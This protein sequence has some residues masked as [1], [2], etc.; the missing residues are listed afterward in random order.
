MAL[1]PNYA[2][3]GTLLAYARFQRITPWEG[4]QSVFR[5]TD[6]GLNWSL[7]MTATTGTEPPPPEELLPAGP[8]LPALR[9]RSAGYGRTA[10]RSTD[11]GQTWEPL[12]I[13]R[14]PDFNVRAILPSPTVEADHTIYVLSDYDLFRSTDNGQTWER[15]SD[16][17]LAGRDYFHRLSAGAISPLLDNGRYQIFIGTA[18]GEF[19]SL[20]PAAL[21]WEQVHITAQWPTV[22]EGEWVGEIEIAPNG[23]LWLGTWGNGLVRYAEG[24]IMARHTVTDGLPSQFIGGIALAPDGTVWAGGDL[25]PGIA[26]FDGQSWTPHPF[27]E[28]DFVGGVLDMA[29]GPDGVVWVGA[30][31]SGILRWDGQKWETIT[32][33]EGRTGYRIYDIEIDPGG[34]LWCATTAGLAY[35][36]DGVW[37]GN[38][39]G[40]IMA[41][42][43]GPGGT[44]YLLE[45][46]GA[47]W[48][49]AANE[50]TTL[51]QPPKGL[52]GS[53]AI[54]AANDGALWLGTSEGAFRYDGQAWQQFTAQDGLPHNDVAAIAQDT[55]GQLWFGTRNGAA[56]VEPSALKLNPVAWPTQP[57]PTPTSNP[58]TCT[59]PPHD[60][61]AAAYADQDTAARLGC[62]LAEAAISGAAFQTFEHGLMFWRAASQTIDVLH[63]DGKWTRYNDTWN[64]TQPL[65]DPGL[66]PPEGLWQ[67]VRGFGKVWREQLGGPQAEIGWALQAEQGYEMLLQHFSGGEMFLDTEGTVYI[68]YADGR[69]D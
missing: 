26:S 15:W 65:D 52:L 63:A 38:P 31:A 41:V 5:S 8:P 29:I 36:S 56:R 32:D 60:S 50:W 37:S 54:Y 4:G 59:L 45:G 39:G 28:K 35:Y 17:R 67:P 27:P 23:D 20:D 58:V 10:E 48:R 44:V 47:I 64:E 12:T 11:G 3:D 55:A 69:W 7:L 22:L 18:A 66:T 16:E 14:Q 6:R 33:P 1:S 46:S 2:A 42:E 40:E 9:F 43:F 25:P 49:Y 68:L 13:T 30:Q 62:P 53:R 57:A 21:T 51:P 34:V 19:W 24:A 61:F